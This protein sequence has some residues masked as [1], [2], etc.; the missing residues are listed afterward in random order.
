MI[1]TTTTTGGGGGGRGGGGGG[2]GGAPRIVRARPSFVVRLTGVDK[3]RKAT[4]SVFVDIDW[5]DASQVF[6]FLKQYSEDV[7]EDE[8]DDDGDG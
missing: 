2:G 5:Y 3:D 8:A 6:G 4:P 1:S 7:S